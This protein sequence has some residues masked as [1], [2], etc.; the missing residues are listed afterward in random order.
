MMGI[1]AQEVWKQTGTSPVFGVIPPAASR[2]RSSAVAWV[3]S[4][5]KFTVF[6]LIFI[7]LLKGS[8]FEAFYIPSTS[9]LPTLRNSDYILVPKFVYGLRL[10]FVSETVLDWSSPARGDVVVFLHKAEAP[11]RGRSA[12]EGNLVKRVIGV[13]GDTVE[14][15]GA[16]VLVNGEAIDEPYTVWGLGGRDLSFGPVRVPH[17]SVFVLGDNRDDSQDSRFWHDPFVAVSAIQGRV[18]MVYWSSTDIQ[19]RGA[20]IR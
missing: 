2:M 8:V 17:D 4:T 11:N 7:V 14:V 19:R 9:M 6:F 15:R 5:L 3:L 16:Q 18:L 1:E 20:L 13:S 10:P 12:L